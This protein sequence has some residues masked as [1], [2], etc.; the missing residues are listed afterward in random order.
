MLI[1]GL[2]VGACWL[3]LI[4]LMLALCTVAGSADRAS[5][6]VAALSAPAPEQARDA[7]SA[8]GVQ[9]TVLGL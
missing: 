8:P 3:G 9:G 6:A 5:D 7:T 1:V 2:I 4:F